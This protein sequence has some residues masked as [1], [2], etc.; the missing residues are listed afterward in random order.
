MFFVFLSIRRGAGE[1][2]GWGIET[3]RKEGRKEE[4]RGKGSVVGP[5]KFRIFTICP[6]IEKVYNN[7]NSYLPCIEHLSLSDNFLRTCFNFF[8]SHKYSIKQ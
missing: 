8:P 6:F 2:E 5:T 7:D 3:G 1:K 4:G